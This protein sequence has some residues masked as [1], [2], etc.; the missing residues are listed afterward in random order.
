MRKRSAVTTA[1]LSLFGVFVLA[2]AI[3]EPAPFDPGDPDD[4][5]TATSTAQAPPDP[6]SSRSSMEGVYTYS[7]MDEYVEVVVDQHMNPWLNETWPGMREPFVLYVDSGESGPQD[8]TDAEGNPGTYTGL[9]Y[10]YC[11]GDETVYVG[12][13][14]LWE[15]YSETGDAGP[16]MGLAHEYGHHIQYELDVPAPFT[17]AQSIDFENQADCIA[18]AWAGWMEAKGALDTEENSPNGRAD[19]ED[20]EL[21]FPIIASAEDEGAD[22]DHGTLEEREQAFSDGFL[23]GESACGL[24]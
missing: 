9:S 22:R 13:D 4:P 23:G 7:T 8:C 17:A 24:A 6:T 16:A 12:Q 5:T 21:M 1:A 14:T 2:C 19:L 3:P 20:I 15:F 11:P 10:E 18:G